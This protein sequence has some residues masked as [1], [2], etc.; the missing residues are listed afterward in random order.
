MGR[1]AHVTMVTKLEHGMDSDGHDD[2]KELSSADTEDEGGEE[3]DDSRLTYT[4]IINKKIQTL[5]VW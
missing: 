5:W 1:H 4:Q 2:A 3:G